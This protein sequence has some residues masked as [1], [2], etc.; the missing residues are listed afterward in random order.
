[1][2]NEY[3]YHVSNHHCVYSYIDSIANAKQ[4]GDVQYLKSSVPR[5]SPAIIVSKHANIK[6]AEVKKL[7]EQ[8][9]QSQEREIAQWKQ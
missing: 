2:K 8:I 5:H 6:D 4:I 1:M 9:I 7:A 3:R